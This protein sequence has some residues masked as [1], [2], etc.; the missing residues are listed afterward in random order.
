MNTDLLQLIDSMPWQQ[1]SHAYGPAKDAPVELRR[2]MAADVEERMDAICGFL[3][4]SAFHQYSI[5]SA[6]PYVIRCVA[7]MLAL[8]DLPE[9]PCGMN[10]RPMAYELLHFIRICAEQ[11]QEAIEGTTAF[12]APTIE[13]VVSEVMPVLERYLAHSESKTRE[14]A[15]VLKTLVE[16][17]RTE[18]DPR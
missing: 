17:W 9:L 6:T 13:E 3:Y 7:N 8:E 11:G 4:S 12:D 2:L 15:I 1:V 14:E 10:E 16:K 5:Y 18:T